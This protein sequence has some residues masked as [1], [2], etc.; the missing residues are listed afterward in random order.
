[1]TFQLVR[2]GE[3]KMWA[4]MLPGLRSTLCRL[5]SQV[6]VSVKGNLLLPT[7]KS[8]SLIASSR[9]WLHQISRNMSIPSHFHSSTLTVKHFPAMH[10]SHLNL[11]PLSQMKVQSRGVVICSKRRGKK[12]TVK[13]VTARF[14]RTGSGKL[15]Y[16]PAGH[17]HNMLSK[18]W[19]RRRNLRKPRY[20]NKT[21]LK[22]LNKMISGW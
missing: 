4:S 9:A 13:A 1:M 2:S 3:E 14:R 6:Q 18:S 19:N 16:W 21:Q 12:K 5:T 7:Q 17:V 15:K 20:A 22:T 11:L 10:N 8:S